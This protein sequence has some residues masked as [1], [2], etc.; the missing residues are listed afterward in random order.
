M[1]DNGMIL[2]IRSQMFRV[3][4][5]PLFNGK[6]FFYGDP[7]Q[8]LEAA[9]QLIDFMQEEWRDWQFHGFPQLLET[10]PVQF[11]EHSEIYIVADNGVKYAIDNAG[12]FQI[13]N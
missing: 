13:M 1:L 5:R 6:I 12:E 11:L 7:V 9:R 2:H 4:L 3:Q 10:N 8:T